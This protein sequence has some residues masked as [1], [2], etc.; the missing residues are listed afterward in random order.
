MKACFATALGAWESEAYWANFWYQSDKTRRE[1]LI[2]ALMGRTNDEIR[3]IKDAFSDKKYDNSLARCMRTEL[4]EDRFKKAIMLALEER[5]M[6]DHVNGLVDA[7][8]VAQDVD[9][10]YRALGAD[11]GG[12][13]TMLAIV[14]LRSDSHLR[15]VLKEYDRVHGAIFA[16]ECLRKSS[17]LVVR[18]FLRLSVY[19]AML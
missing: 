6:D 15:Q 19:T 18:Y 1:L 14:V 16:R 5:R 12:E 8:L 10:L 2:E 11:R 9:D 7:V 17:N 4:R 13:S 3:A